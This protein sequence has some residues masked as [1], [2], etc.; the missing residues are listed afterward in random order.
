MDSSKELPSISILSPTYNHERYI[1]ECILSVQAQSFSSWE[2]IIL[3]D[4]STDG[5][6]EKARFFAKA[7]PRIHVYTQENVGVFRL[8]ETYNKGLELSKGK[9]IAILEC[10]DLWVP[11]KL[12]NQF[13]ILENNPG[14]V[15]AWG[16]AELINADNTQS[17]Y[18][19]PQKN[20]L[21]I[22]LFNNTPPGT[23]IELALKGAWLPALTLLIRKEILEE[24]GGFIQTDNMPLVDFPTILSLSKK[25][26]FHFEDRVLGKWR[27]YATQTTKKYTV[28]IYN[29]MYSFL[30]RHLPEVS[31]V[32]TEQKNHILHHYKML[33]LVAYSRSGRYKLI[34][35]DFKSARKDYIKALIFPASG[36]WIWRLRAL[37]GLGMSLIHMDVEG[38]AKLLG[39][40]T[41]KN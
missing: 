32:S 5:T 34:R 35:K 7:D 10:D 13:D 19:S 14:I 27:I 39:K 22:D 12:K 29:G 26:S 23:V 25:G 21:S 28:E 36:K 17:Y 37:V 24:I 3:D 18:I 11:D 20:D 31:T 8:S 30:R 9:Y 4:G 6:L 1:E 38:I 40:K 2:M 15:I 16:K 33:C 41:Y